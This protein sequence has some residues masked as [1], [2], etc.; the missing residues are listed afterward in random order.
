MKLYKDG[1]EIESDKDQLSIMLE[2]GWF[3]SKDEDLDPPEEIKEE[4]KVEVKSLKI[5]P[6][7]K[8]KKITKE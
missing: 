3:M 1:M 2:G 8:P 4:E 5:K 6:K 7:R